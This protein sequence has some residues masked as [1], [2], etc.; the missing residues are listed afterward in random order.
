MALRRGAQTVWPFVAALTLSITLA[1]CGGGG[2]G[3]GSAGDPGLSD[4]AALGKKI[5]FDPSLSASGRMACSTCHDPAF[6]HAQNNALPV[7]SGGAG[8]DVPGFRA[9]PSLNYLEKNPS[10]F[11]DSEGTPTGGFNRDGRAQTLADQAQRPFL[12]AHEM[13]NGTPDVVVQKLAAAAYA[14]DF[15]R[16][17]GSA[18]FADIDTAFLRAR[19][20]L[21][22]YEREDPAFHPYDS[23][24]DAFLAGRATLTAQEIRGLALYQDPTKGNCSGCHPSARGSDGTP[25]SPPLF[26][27][28]TYDNLGLPRNMAIPANADPAYLDMGLCG[29]ER[30]DLAGRRDL[31][32]AFKVPTLRNVATRK[33]FFHNGAFSSLKDALTFYVQRDTNPEKWYPMGSSGALEKFNDLPPDLAGNVNTTEVPYNRKEGEPP[34][35]TDAEIDD[36]VAFLQTLTD[37]YTP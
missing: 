12:A 36:V 11:F 21:E 20:A 17:F 24:Y 15:R 10:F 16:V 14:D 37:G 1:A 31:C 2:G 28:F 8:L 35:L 4:R 13:A 34:A 3:A 7:Q 29:P 6:A 25:N 5:F 18:I 30:T 27:D 26:T 19:Q 22:A 33:V 9:V 32:G 23:K